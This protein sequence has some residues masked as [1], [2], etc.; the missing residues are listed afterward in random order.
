[1]S[2]LIP[3]TLLYVLICLYSDVFYCG[4]EYQ[5]YGREEAIAALKY[6]LSHEVL[7]YVIVVAV[8][9]LMIYFNV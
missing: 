2:A 6:M 7:I 8:I 3:F 5:D 1:M 9:T 4:A